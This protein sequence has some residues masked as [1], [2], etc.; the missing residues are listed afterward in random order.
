MKMLV[1]LMKT[2]WD[3]ILFFIIAGVIVHLLIL[4]PSYDHNYSKDSQ[5]KEAIGRIDQEIQKSYNLIDQRLDQL[6]EKLNNINSYMN[7]LGTKEVHV[8]A[9][10]ADPR[11]TDSTPFETACLTEPT[12]YT[13]GTKIYVK[14]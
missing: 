9:Y 12:L 5:I 8:T 3:V 10:T 13:T 6:E 14:N 11:Q 2:N 7:E 1:N 4:S